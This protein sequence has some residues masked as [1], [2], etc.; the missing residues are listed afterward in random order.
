MSLIT[1]IS[2]GTGMV[3]GYYYFLTAFTSVFVRCQSRL[4]YV[5]SFPD[6]FWLLQDYRLSSLQIHRTNQ[7]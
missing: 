6:P 2:Y 3:S 5:S 7:F 1:D 4:L